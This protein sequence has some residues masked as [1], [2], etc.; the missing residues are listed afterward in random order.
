M[1]YL[2]STLLI[3]TVS[4][5]HMCGQAKMRKLS[6]SINHPSLNL[7]A[8]FINTDAN[9][10]VFLSD[11]TEDRLPAPFFTVREATD[12]RDPAMLPKTV[13][14][15]LNFLRG[16]GLS[17]DGKKLY[18][19]TI[20]S[21]S[22]G[23]YDIFSSDV[24]GSVFGEPVNLGAPINSKSNEACPS[25]TPDGNTMYFMRCDK[26][27]PN[28]AEGCKIIRIAKKSNGQW[29]EPT[30]MPA[31]INAGNSQT[32]R[33][34]AD[35]E[36][37]IFSS[38]KLSPNKGGMDLYVTRFSNGA[39]T[40]PLALEFTNTSK[41]DQYVSVSALGRYLLRDSQGTKKNELVEYLMPED[42]RPKGMMR[43]EGKVADPSGGI[44]SAYIS[45]NDLASQKRFYSGRPGSDGSFMF[46]LKEG[47][48]Y[49]FAIDPEQ[50]NVT[51]FSKLYDLTTDKI[52]QSE[53]VSATLKPLAAGDELQ[54]DLIR[55]K[56]F[57]SEVDGAASSGEFKR[58]VRLV[59]A[60]P[61]M[62]FQVQVL[63]NGYLEDSLQSNPDLTEVMIDSVIYEYH[64]VDSLGQ[65]TSEDSLAV[66]TLYHNNR[67]NAQ[68]KA[69]VDYLV[70]QGVSSDRLSFFGNAIPATVPDNKKLLIKLVS[71]K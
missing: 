23:G 33:I 8:P 26:M 68:A 44:V 24:K 2:L 27:E 19:S 57:S 61:T 1:R 41:D 60:N 71:G 18:V 7:Y 46:Y 9:A 56:P 43:V 15:R 38:D 45:A 25:F 3:M 69:I 20:K 13:H 51:Y 55:F 17:P 4:T 66:K 11:N 53:K 10:M 47:S 63:L 42:V 67:T 59:N 21:P 49:E 34:M 37:L 62:K 52:P 5:M 6:S 12:W 35:G 50:S 30:E 31:S 36:T 65:P 39:W 14:S 40:S 29:D 64:G 16:F 48:K 28:K 58:I 70:A 22:V 54:T 32:P